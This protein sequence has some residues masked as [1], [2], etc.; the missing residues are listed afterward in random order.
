MS[1]QTQNCR[2][3]DSPYRSFCQQ[4]T[5]RSDKFCT[6]TNPANFITASTKVTG[7]NYFECSESNKKHRICKNCCESHQNDKEKLQ[8]PNDKYRKEFSSRS[9]VES[10]KISEEN[11][12]SSVK[13]SNKSKKSAI[14]RYCL[15]EDVGDENFSPSKE[16]SD[17]SSKAQS[18][19]RDTCIKSPHFISCKCKSCV[20]QTTLQ[21]SKTNT[22]HGPCR[23][24]IFI[25]CEKSPNDSGT[26]CRCSKVQVHKSTGCDCHVIKIHSVKCSSLENYCCPCKKK[27]P[28]K[29]LESQSCQTE[30]VIVQKKDLIAGPEIIKPKKGQEISVPCEKKIEIEIKKPA[31]EKFPCTPKVSIERKLEKNCNVEIIEKKIQEKTCNDIAVQAKNSTPLLECHCLKKDKKE[32]RVEEIDDHPRHYFLKIEEKEVEEVCYDEKQR[33]PL[34]VSK[35]L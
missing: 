35:Y 25:N 21:T 18:I 26:R 31:E 33:K 6:S 9:V 13:S 8:N 17:R 12:V 20:K 11:W 2:Q 14:L 22:P 5:S 10:N 29:K 7:A 27:S 28:Q 19:V 3:V 32:K 15:G 30:Q 24:N 34:E 23:S 4:S 1:S 16:D